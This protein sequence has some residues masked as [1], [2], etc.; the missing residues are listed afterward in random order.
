[1]TTHDEA[2]LV[3]RMIRGA[4]RT[5]GAAI[6]L[7]LAAMLRKASEIAQAKSGSVTDVPGLDGAYLRGVLA[8]LTEVSLSL[9]VLSVAIAA[10]LGVWA[11]VGL[12]WPLPRKRRTAEVPL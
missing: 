3:L 6:F 2:T 8:T 12:L 7:G 9:A 1:M 11:L 4:A 10:C 5:A